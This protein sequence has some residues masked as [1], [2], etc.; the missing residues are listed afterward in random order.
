MG[1][2]NELQ[3]ILKALKGG[4]L[5][6]ST[7]Q[8]IAMLLRDGNTVYLSAI[9]ELA[10]RQEWAELNDRFYRTLAFGTGGLRVLMIVKFMNEYVSVNSGAVEK[11][12][13]LCG[14]MSATYA[15]Q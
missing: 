10:H 6:D 13:L 1:N 11:Q 4:A 9:E 5:L 14:A 12:Y 3:T 2:R 15:H 8:N 7:N